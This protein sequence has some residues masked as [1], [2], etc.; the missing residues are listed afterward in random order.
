[1]RRFV[2]AAVPVVVIAFVG[3]SAQSGGRELAAGDTD[4]EATQYIVDRYG[5][6]VLLNPV[7]AP[8]TILLWIAAPAFLVI[9]GIVVFLGLRRRRSIPTGSETL[10]EAESRALSELEKPARGR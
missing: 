10:S 9:G 3:V 6:F 7:V 4:A 5:E 8:H 1:M 2:I